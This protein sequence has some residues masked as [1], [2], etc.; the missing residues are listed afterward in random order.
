MGK[1]FYIMGKSSTGKDTIYSELLSRKEL[2]LKPLI[3]YTTRPIR[4]NEMDGVQYHFVTVDDL[5]KMQE[6]GK[7][8]ELRVYQT[9]HGPWHYFTADGEA[10]DM[11]NYDYIGLGTPESFVKIKNYYGEDRVIPIY[12]E[13]EDGL[14]LQ[15]ALDR[16]R[17][18]EEP[19]Y[20]E[21]CRRFLAD[22]KDFCE[23]NITAAGIRKR[24]YN[25][26]MLQTCI[27]EVMQL[28]TKEIQKS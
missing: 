26:E 24:F 14:R 25:N 23:E 1:L 3:I 4:S 2:E 12:I 28:V 7:V 8:I 22:Q 13:V 21:M 9:M 16:E 5:N 20:E 11:E 10:V 27:E 19:K 6:E 18:M 15:R 17:S